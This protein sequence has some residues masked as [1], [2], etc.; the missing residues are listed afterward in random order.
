MAISDIDAPWLYAS[1][2]EQLRALWRAARPD[3]IAAIE[4]VY[5]LGAT[6]ALAGGPYGLL[7]PASGQ[8]IGYGARFAAG[9]LVLALAALVIHYA[10]EI[11]DTDTDALT[12]P[13][14]YSGGSGAVVESDV[15]EAFL[16]RAWLGTAAV[17]ASVV[18]WTAS[19][20]LLPLRSLPVLCVAVALGVAY[21]LPPAALVRRGLGEAVNA[22]LVGVAVPAYAI[23][24]VGTPTWAAG[25]AVA[26]LTALLGCTYLAIHWPDREAD[27][28]V[29][30]RTL[31]VRWSARGLRRAY[32]LCCLAAL[33]AT[34]LG[35]HVGALP[36]AVVLVHALVAPLVV[37]GYRR[38]TRQRSPGPAV[39][40]SLALVAASAVAWG[41]LA[42][43]GSV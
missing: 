36:T 31:A 34:A 4:L 29:D 27:A 40:P 3:Q 12:E 2:A 23:S 35:W 42:A 22:V 10:D 13:T 19:T 8:P 7:E 18:A 37:R 33:L 15:S 9:A 43:G 38:V 25:L 32:A 1:R 5:C 16:V 14:P 30:K 28:A 20:G 11:A 21:S 24:L 6:V 39:L 26:P 41:W 17:A